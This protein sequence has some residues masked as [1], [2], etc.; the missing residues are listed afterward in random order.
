MALDETL[1]AMAGEYVL[2]TLAAA[3]RLE[4]QTLLSQNRDFASA[5][6]EWTERLLVFQEEPVALP[7]R[8]LRCASSEARGEESDT[9][10]W[11]SEDVEDPGTRCD[12]VAAERV[13]EK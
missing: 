12:G 8:R 7:S 1:E 6:D 10:V 13:S 9:V 3:E 11:I 5:V 2:G 4:A